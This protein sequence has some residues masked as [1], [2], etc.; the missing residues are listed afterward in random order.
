M[1]EHA[2]KR[3]FYEYKTYAAIWGA[4]IKHDPYK[5]EIVRNPDEYKGMTEE[6]KKIATEKAKW[7]LGKIRL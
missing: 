6:E 1:Y 5:E 3:K 7:N 2:Q 4:E